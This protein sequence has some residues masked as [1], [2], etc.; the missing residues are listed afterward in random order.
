[1]DQS[2]WIVLPLD[3]AEGALHDRVIR[4]IHAYDAEGTP[5][6]I[7]EIVR[8]TG[9]S[10]SSVIRVLS[11]LVDLGLVLHSVT[12]FRGRHYRTSLTWTTPEQ[13]AKEYEMALLMRL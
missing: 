13:V 5:F 12:A 9:V 8:V 11:K 6:A 7:H 10:R 2:P 3:N 1:M 4:E